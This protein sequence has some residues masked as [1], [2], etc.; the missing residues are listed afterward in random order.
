MRRLMG[1]G[2]L[3]PNKTV[4]EA[5]LREKVGETATPQGGDAKSDAAA[6]KAKSATK[7]KKG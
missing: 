1:V 3:H 5:A 6:T 2:H 7:A 4:H